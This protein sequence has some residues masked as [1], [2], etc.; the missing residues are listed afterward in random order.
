MNRIQS[1]V[2][3]KLLDK[4]EASKTF[5][6]DNKR[7]QQFTILIDQQFPRYKDDA[8]YDYFVE[9]NDSLREL[10]EADYIFI[11]E[12]KNGT[13]T[14]AILNTEALEKCYAY[15]S[16]KPKKDEQV[17]LLDIWQTF[18]LSQ[19]ELMPIRN[20][21]QVQRERMQQ[22]RNIEYFDGDLKKYVDILNMAI[23]VA[24]NSEEIFVRDFSIRLFR[25]SKRVEQLASKV[26]SL[27]YTYGDF[28]EKETVLE[29]C[30]I[31]HTPTY[32]MIKGNVKINIQS[33]VLDLS[34][35]KGDISFSTVSLEELSEITVM[36]NRVVTIENLTSFH[37]YGDKSDCVIYLG[38]F[39]NKTKRRF[40][41]FLYEHNR[42]VTYYHFG[43]IDAGGFYILEHLIRKTGIQFHSLYMDKATFLSHKEDTKKLTNHDRTRL[44]KLRDELVRKEKDGKLTENYMEVIDC[45]LEMG[46]KLEQEAVKI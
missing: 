17:W 41:K 44:H 10:E 34:R 36:G 25:D 13:I 32:V 28:E 3:N 31:V 40:I 11:Q 5:Q 26:S 22:N 30:G 42:D 9:V 12:R 37:D 23:A 6:G 16:R 7:K 38:G 8:D 43:D 14:R 19:N 35:L 29:E 39:H 21:L 24:Q 20:Y 1:T 15:M 18:D 27:L 33:Q 46:C 4:Y 2:I 45:M